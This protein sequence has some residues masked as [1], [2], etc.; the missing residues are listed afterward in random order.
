MG[1]RDASFP[2]VLT[3]TVSTGEGKFE[4]VWNTV[5]NCMAASLGVLASAYNA[6]GAW[7]VNRNG[8]GHTAEEEAI[9]T[10]AAV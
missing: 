5:S 9:E 3:Y 8:L 1:C 2:A 7:R 10:A 6:D 4:K